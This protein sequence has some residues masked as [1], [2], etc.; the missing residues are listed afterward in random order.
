MQLLLAQAVVL[1]SEVLGRVLEALRVE[2]EFAGLYVELVA[3]GLEVLV[4]AEVLLGLEDEDLLRPDLVEGLDSS[5]LERL[6][7][8]TA[9]LLL[10]LGVVFGRGALRVLQPACW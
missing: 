4:E 5:P 10:I 3:D 1:D 6:W 8:T 7:L 2:D 9:T